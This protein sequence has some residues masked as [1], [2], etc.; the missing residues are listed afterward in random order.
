MCGSLV[1]IEFDN[2][3]PNGG[4]QATS[5][6]SSST[7]FT[8][9][10]TGGSTGLRGSPNGTWG[11]KGHTT[12]A[13][14]RGS[15]SA[16]KESPNSADLRSTAAAVT[17]SNKLDS[18]MKIDGERKG[19]GITPPVDVKSAQQGPTPL[20]PDSDAYVMACRDRFIGIAKSLVGE[21]VVLSMH[22]GAVHEGV[23]HTC[24]PFRSAPFSILLK[25]VKTKKW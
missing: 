7:L 15:G 4:S 11:R 1:S 9:S 8:P 10:R 23:L 25:H 16:S 3:M 2:R 13:M 22:N 14:H 19:G 21:H 12:S 18:A 17:G 24:T 5:F 20:S 6:H